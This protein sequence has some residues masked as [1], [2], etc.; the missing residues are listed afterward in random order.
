MKYKLIPIFLFSTFYFL[1]STNVA[2]GQHFTSTNYII[3]WGN[4]NITSGKKTS[5]N[6]L[7]TDT[8][9]QNAPGPYTSIG[10]TLKSGF[11]YIYDTFNQFTFV[12]NNLNMN[13]GTLV[14]GIASTATNTITI[15]TPSGHGYQILAFQNHPLSLGSGITIPNTACNIGSTC[16]ATLANVWTNSTDYGFGFNA[17]GINT[18]GVA[19]GIGTS[20]YFAD[21]TYYRP[22]STSGNVFMSSTK[23]IK[24]HIARISYKA[25]ISAVQSAGFYQNA[26]T[27]VAVPKY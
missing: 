18:S 8:V 20:D 19:T 17:I 23:P 2:F 11:Q 25:L 27:F 12:I 4:F 3:D 15:T 9:G 7:L 14:A 1:L 13:L 24:N 16:T 6:Y 22:F 5:T 10:Y 26:I 21:N